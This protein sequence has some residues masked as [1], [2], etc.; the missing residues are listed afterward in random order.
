MEKPH[1]LKLPFINII[2]M[3]SGVEPWLHQWREQQIPGS[4]PGIAQ[5]DVMGRNGKTLREIIHAGIQFFKAGGIQVFEPDC[6]RILVPVTM[7][8]AVCCTGLAHRSSPAADIPDP[9]PY[10][11]GI[12]RK[13]ISSK[14]A[15][16]NK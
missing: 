4:I 3:E 1:L 2:S 8:Q 7:P 15:Y 12:L 13:T 16:Y 10:R 14:E 5:V 11:N 6:D 9:V